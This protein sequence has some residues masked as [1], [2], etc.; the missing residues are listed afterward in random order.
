ML[1]KYPL[2]FRFVRGLLLIAL[3]VVSIGAASLLIA[4]SW[5]DGGTSFT[6]AFL[7]V[8]ASAIVG[9]IA[10]WL[11]AIGARSRSSKTLDGLLA[12]S[13]ADFEMAV[14]RL[15]RRQGYRD[16]S[17]VG[18]PGDLAVDILCRERGGASV[19]VQCKRKAR[20]HRVGSAELQQFIGMITVHHGADVGIYVTTSS[21]TKPAIELAEVHEIM[22]I[23][24]EMLSEL[25]RGKRRLGRKP[26]TRAA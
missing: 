21:Y 7:L 15:L 16:V 11:A 6:I 22:L 19:A 18:G 8:F 1:L 17:V 14:A 25:V 20:G 3:L 10:L 24:G 4:S 2:R 26:L 9:V 5:T 23:D 12:L 13:P